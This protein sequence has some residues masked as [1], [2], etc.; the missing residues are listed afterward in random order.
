MPRR[1][2][3]AELQ[4]LFA[5]RDQGRL[6]ETEFQRRKAHLLQISAC[7]LPA[8]APDPVGTAARVAAVAGAT[9]LL[10]LAAIGMAR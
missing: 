8:M 4:H 10:V 6:G 9:A 2:I 7:C 5:Q 3:G 1:T